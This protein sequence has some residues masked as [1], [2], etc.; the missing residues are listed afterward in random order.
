MQMIGKVLPIVFGVFSLN[1]PA[2]LVLYF[3]VSNLWRLGQQE[4]ILRKIHL[5][6]R[7]RARGEEE[8]KPAEADTTEALDVESRP[9]AK[10]AEQAKPATPAT[11][12]PPEEVVRDHGPRA[13]PSPRRRRR[14]PAPAPGGSA[15]CSGCPLRPMESRHP[16]PARRASRRRRRGPAGAGGSGRAGAGRANQGRR[17]RNKKRKR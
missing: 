1:F 17:R 2:G 12:P 16:Q 8:L 7:E 5:P 3:L 11:A 9:K 14:G 4:L 10:P 6:H 13:E 15:A